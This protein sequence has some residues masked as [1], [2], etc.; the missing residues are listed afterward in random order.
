MSCSARQEHQALL[1]AGYSVLSHL[2]KGHSHASLPQRL[3]TTP[4]PHLFVGFL[5]DAPM[6]AASH[7][8]NRS[9]LEIDTGRQIGSVNGALIDPTDRRVAALRVNTGL[10]HRDRFV[11]WQDLQGTGPDALTIRSEDALLNRSDVDPNHTHL[12]HLQGRAVFT[13]SGERLGEIADYQMDVGTG[14]LIGFEVQPSGA[15]KGLFGGSGATHFHVPV[16]QIVTIGAE[17][18]VVQNG[19]RE[20]L[21]GPVS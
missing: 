7:L 2:L 11:R 21:H 12:D 17:S 14:S 15:S 19:V 10:L 13:E 6:H 8:M 18:L 1:S 16:D 5:D 3:F 9:V 20:S 4:S